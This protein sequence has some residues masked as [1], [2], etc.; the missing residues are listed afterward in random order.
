MW[1]WGF[2][3]CFCLL[4]FIFSIAMN[5]LSVN[6]YRC[7]NYLNFGLWKPLEV[8][9]WNQ[10]AHLQESLD[11]FLAVWHDKMFQAYFYLIS[12]PDC[13]LKRAWLYFSG[14]CYLET[15]LVL[16][17]L[18]VDYCYLLFLRLFSRQLEERLFCF[19]F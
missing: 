13:R 14:N 3:L 7:L 6:S 8:C 5:A 16:G 17:V 10:L 9:S 2:C 12:A 4:F 15:S 1:Q 11:S 18:I 19:V